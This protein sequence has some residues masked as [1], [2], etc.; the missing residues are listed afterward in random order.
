MKKRLAAYDVP[1]AVEKMEGAGLDTEAQ[2]ALW[3]LFDSKQRSAMKRFMAE[4]KPSTENPEAALD[5][6]AVAAME[7]D[8]S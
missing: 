5:R 3:T 6:E 1:G 4:A 2:V 7:R 8:Q